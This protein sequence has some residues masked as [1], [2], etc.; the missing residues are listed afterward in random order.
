MNKRAAAIAETPAA[1]K[2]AQDREKTG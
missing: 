1:A 2:Q